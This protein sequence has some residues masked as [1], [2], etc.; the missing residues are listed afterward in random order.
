M[1]IS[2]MGETEK[3]FLIETIKYFVDSLWKAKPREL[4]C[5][6]VAPTGLAAF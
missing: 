6:K 2:G 4:S 3:L 5:A 1:F